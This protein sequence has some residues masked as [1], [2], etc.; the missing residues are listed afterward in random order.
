MGI[1]RGHER[2]LPGERAAEVSDWHGAGTV[3][4]VDGEE[5]FH[6]LR[7][8][9]P[10]VR[11]V[12]SSGYTEQDITSRFM[13]EGRVGFLQKPYTIAHLAER[14]RAALEGTGPSAGEIG[15]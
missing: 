12:M 6:E 4:L 1:V 15:G 5:T 11:V 10:E 8:L 14:L 7:A 13:D 2:A 3:L 9:D